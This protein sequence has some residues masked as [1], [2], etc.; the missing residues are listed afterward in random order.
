MAWMAARFRHDAGDDWLEGWLAEHELDDLLT[1]HRAEDLTPGEAER[2]RAIAA[3]GEPRQARFNL[4]MTAGL[5]PADCRVPALLAGLRDAD[6]YMRVAACVG[7]QEAELPGDAWPAIRDA[8]IE[9]LGDSIPAIRNRA[10]VALAHK[11]RRG[12]G[13]LLARAAMA[14]P[15][16]QGNLFIAL[17]RSGEPDHA[18]P[19]VPMALERPAPPDVRAWLEAWNRA[20]RM[21]TDP[22]K[23]AL[24]PSL[25]YIPNLDE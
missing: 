21:E 17:V 11:A 19:L 23:V 16:E 4:L 24:L 12:D 14:A 9:C 13:A 2:V 6:P 3:T 25:G 22:P 10:S 7:A 5:L 18:T 15:D 8:L 1:A 20:G